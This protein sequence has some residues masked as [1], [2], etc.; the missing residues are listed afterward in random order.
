[1]DQE[2]KE[3]VDKI[4]KTV[5]TFSKYQ[6]DNRD[7]I[8]KSKAC[9]Q[10]RIVEQPFLVDSALAQKLKF[11][12]LEMDIHKE[13]KNIQRALLYLQLHPCYITKILKSN[14]ICYADKK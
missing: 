11:K 2:M 5:Y 7:K 10:A 8:Q 1:M 6:I 14:L 4:L 12:G 9:V 13:K 3:V